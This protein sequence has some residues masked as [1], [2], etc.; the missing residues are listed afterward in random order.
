MNSLR[1]RQSWV[2]STLG[3]LALGLAGAMLPA[4]A[5]NY[6]G[7]LDTSL[8]PPQIPHFLQ[9]IPG[10]FRY[11]LDLGGGG[12]Y[13]DAD[14]ATA[15]AVQ[16]DGKIV[17][18]GFS[19]NNNLGTDQ[20]ACIIQRFN[21]DGS[22]DSGFGSAGRVVQNFNP[23]GGR[24]DCFLTSVALQGDGK[25]VVAGNIADATSGERALIERLNA[26]GSFDHSFAGKGYYVVPNHN[27]AFAA[28]KVNPAGPIYAA[29]RGA[30]FY[31]PAHTDNDFYFA[32]FSSTG[33]LVQE[34]TTF[35][36]LGAD[37]D[38]RANAMVLNGNFGL[39][40]IYLI[41]NAASAPYGDLDH[42]QCAIA[43]YVYSLNDSAFVPD[44]TF[45]GAG[46]T[47]FDILG[48]S[49]E[50]DTYCRAAV[51]RKGGG[52]F[53]GGETYFISSFSLPAGRASEFALG[54]I[55]GSGAVVQLGNQSSSNT[56]QASAYPGVYNGIFGMARTPDGELIVTGYAGTND[57]NRQPSDAG[58]LAFSPNLLL[59]IGFGTSGP[60]MTILSLDV[61]INTPQSEWTT[62]LA[63]DNHGRI[64]LVGERSYAIESF[65]GDYDWLISRLNMSDVI[66]RDG[67][68]GVVP[69]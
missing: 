26:N 45:N 8:S 40:K 57:A 50:G 69:D 12:Y 1:H 37:K 14:S 48:P 36:D 24:N 58:V 9:G 67:L 10:L 47:S 2:S 56:F 64:V 31:G 6:D 15:V 20:N 13:S 29:G 19:W 62:A 49:N 22:V 16:V 46:A 44:T 35:F 3:V 43:A 34:L 30:G 41:G 38:D 21:I 23:S 53:V 54:E 4:F 33:T 60:G 18:A 7:S 42:H 65:P 17:V 51:A 55:N 28:V 61:P 59:D 27:T 63:L 32:A 66:F 25:I 39:P 11:A 68:D 52:V 5:T